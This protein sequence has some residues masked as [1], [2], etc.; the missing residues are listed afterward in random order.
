[1]KKIVIFDADAELNPIMKFQTSSGN[2]METRMTFY[3]TNRSIRTP[4]VV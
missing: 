1:M 4:S 2:D 3:L